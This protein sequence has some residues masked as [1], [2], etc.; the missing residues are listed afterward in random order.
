MNYWIKGLAALSLGATLALPALAQ[1]APTPNTEISGTISVWT[2]PN[3]DR[4]FAALMPTF[5]EAFPN[6]KVEVQGYPNGNNAYL[7]NLQR[8]LLSGSGPD[9][10]MIEISQ[11]ALL[12]ERPQWVDLSQDPYNAD[13]LMA[14]F[15]PFTVNNVTLEDGKIVALPKHTGPGGMFYRRDIFEEAGLPTEPEEVAALF[16]DWDAF[17]EQGKKLVVPNERW[18]IGSGEEIVGPMIAQ[19]GISYFDAEGNLQLDNPVFREAL[20]RVQEAGEAGLISPF[21][22][23]SPEWQGAFQRGQLATALYGNWFGGLL[24]RAYATDQAG[25]W[26]VATAPGN[27]ESRSFNSGGDYIGIL[28]TS[29]NK[30]AAWA[31]IHWLVTADESLKQQYQNDDLYP[32]YMPALEQD[33]MNFEDPYYAGQNVNEVFA[34]V[35]AELIPTTLNEHDTIAIPAMRTAIDNVAKGIMS[36]D[37]ALAAAKAEIE[38]KM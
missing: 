4:T 27:G 20:E 6:I 24:K 22:T 35:Q 33:W 16:S 28:E 32:A 23:W 9:V 12:R 11:M 7:N 29:D 31:F 30:E 5:N 3:N 26:G 38:A 25:L 34:P 18:M 13:E 2:W 19:A 15:A 21:T 1:D 37:E 36:V 8:A 14:D 10:A 17:I